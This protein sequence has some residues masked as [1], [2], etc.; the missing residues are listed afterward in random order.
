VQESSQ[1]PGATIAAMTRVAQ[2]LGDGADPEHVLETVTRAALDAIPGADYVTITMAH[3]DGTLKTLAPTHE[4]G[5][6]ADVAQYELG[7][8]PC[9]TGV[10][11]EKTVRSEDLSSEQRWPQYTR[12][13][14]ELGLG[15]QMAVEIFRAGGTTAGLNLYSKTRGA[16]DASHDIV[17][18]FG[19]QAA[20]AMNFVRTTQTLKEAL[21]SRKM[22]GQAIGILMERYHLDEDQAFAF[23][24]RASQDGNVKLRSVAQKIVDVGNARPDGEKS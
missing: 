21:A 16:F 12:R 5:R 1:G 15:S 13:A 24:V 17:E 4:V 14:I 2:S 8:G 11:A 10:L 18:L 23:L 7:E 3:A 19:S 20:I 22:I 6:L 9:L